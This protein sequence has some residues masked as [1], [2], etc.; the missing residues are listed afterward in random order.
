MADPTLDEIDEYVAGFKTLDG[1]LSDW[2]QRYGWDWCA[3]WGVLDAHGRQL[4]NLKFVTNAALTRP[5]ITA[6]YRRK[7]IYRVDFV[8]DSEC[9]DNDYGA[10]ALGL[11]AVV[12]GPHTH[13]WQENR[14]FIAD[15]GFGELPMRKPVTLPV[16]KPVSIPDS[17]FIRALE[18]VASDLN[19]LIEGRQ[20]D[21]EPPP[22][23]SLFAD[24]NRL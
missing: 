4:G 3:E 9:K 11:P 7:L 12:C 14:A 5:S 1:M 21:V 17:R 20:R 13:P 23:A 22:Q 24:R 15:N 19:I 10:H 8:D 18:V 16:R 2:E 6:T